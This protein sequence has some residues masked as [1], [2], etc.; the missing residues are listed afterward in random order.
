MKLGEFFSGVAETL[1]ARRGNLYEQFYHRQGKD[2]NVRR[3]GPY[4][5]WTR[6]V[7][8]KMVSERV[9]KEDVARVREEIARGKVLDDLLGK[10]WT[11]SENLARKS[12]GK[13]KKSNRSMLRLPPS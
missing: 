7:E 9:P 12:G 6:C 8:G 3:Y 2:G 4:Y 1:P 13:K 5:V 11:L 10:L